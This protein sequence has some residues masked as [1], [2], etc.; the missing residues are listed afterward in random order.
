MKSN[1]SSKH[2]LEYFNKLWRKTTKLAYSRPII[3]FSAL[4][5]IDDNYYLVIIDHLESNSFL[6]N[7]TYSYKGVYR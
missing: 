4:G 7:N 6:R 3:R 5:S 2:K 1:I